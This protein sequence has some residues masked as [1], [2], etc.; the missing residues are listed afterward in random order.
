MSPALTMFIALLVFAAAYVFIITEWINKML[1]SLIGGFLLVITG[2]IT[3]GE[4]FL[5]VDWNVIFF[6]IGMMLVISVLKKTGVFMYVAIKTA[7]LVRGNPLAIMMLMYAITA[8]FAAF[9]DSVTAVMIL[10]PVVMLIC[11][12]LKTTPV[13]YIITMAVA[14]NMGGAATMVGDPPNVILGSAIGKTFLDFVINLAPAAIVS[15]LASLGLIFLFYRKQLQVSLTNRAK[16]MSY[17]E[18]KL[19][20]DK[21]ML[22]ISLTVLGLMLLALALDGYLH[23]GT[24]SISMTAGLILMIVSNRKKMEPVMAKDIDWVTLFFF[25]GLFVI[26]EGLVKTGFINL[27]A[28][29]VIGATGGNPRSTSMAIL[30]LSGVFSAFVDNVPFVAT[31]IP[32]LKHISQVINNAGLMD[33]IWWSLALGTCLGG[34]GTLIGASANIV[35]V[36]IAKQNDFHISF[37]DFTKI[38]VVF[39]LVS[40]LISTAYILIR[41]F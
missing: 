10:V 24:A 3:Q 41:F 33:P 1:A 8:F 9:L 21:R 11:H 4:A 20:T 28:Q 15:V 31:M 36:G 38:S 18:E 14:A 25:I 39:T 2:I 16:L 35:A 22:T 13:P 23:I 32:V 12:E 27:L 29:K 7:K 17:K 34:N 19:I 40:L 26:V 6:L 30:W 5:A 37:W